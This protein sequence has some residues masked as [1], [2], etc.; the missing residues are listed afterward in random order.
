MYSS[1]NKSQMITAVHVW[2]CLCAWKTCHINIIFAKQV[3]STYGEAGFFFFYRSVDLLFLLQGLVRPPHRL[4]LAHVHSDKFGFVSQAVSVCCASKS[5]C[6]IRLVTKSPD[7]A[8][9]V[10]TGMRFQ[11]FAGELWYCKTMPLH[12]N[13]TMPA[14]LVS[15][16][17]HFY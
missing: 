11:T 6:L 17:A 12:T 3:L 2:C 16:S 14:C 1:T 7:L 13:A 9:L 15:W 4:L 5:S 8:C 10:L